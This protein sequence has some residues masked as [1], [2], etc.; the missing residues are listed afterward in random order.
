MVSQS[1]Q[2]KG[3]GFESRYH[4]LVT[5]HEVMK[6]RNQLMENM[7]EDQNV[8]MLTYNVPANLVLTWL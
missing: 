2:I 1:S 3:P 5:Q 6:A 7:P 8:V 4:P